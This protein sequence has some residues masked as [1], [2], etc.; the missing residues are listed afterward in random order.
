MPRAAAYEVRRGAE[1]DTFFQALLLAAA[2]KMA[3]YEE[4][5]ATS[6]EVIIVPMDGHAN[7][8]GALQPVDL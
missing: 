1:P 2:N 8:W 3:R 5:V 6:L 4:Q 7:Q